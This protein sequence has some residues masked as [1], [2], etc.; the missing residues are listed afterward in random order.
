[1]KDH[2]KYFD[3]NKANWNK[4]VDTH[5]NSDF[6]NIEKFLQTKNSLNSIELSEL[7]EIKNKEL[8]H[9]QCH[10]GQDTISL[11]NLGANTTGVDFS[12]KAIQKAIQLTQ[13]TK[14]HSDFICS[15][16][17]NL[18][19]NLTKKFDIIF[20]SYGTIGWLPDINKWA[21]IVSHFLKPGGKFIIVEFHPFIWMFDDNFEKFQYS[22]F[23][24]DEPITEIPSKTYTDGNEELNVVQYSWNH[25]LSDVTNSLILNDLEITS[26][27]EYNYSPYNC[28]PNMI[29]IETGKYVFKMYGDKL[30]LV[31]SLSATKKI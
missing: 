7:G 12:E 13:K 11:A 20:T 10:F 2:K 30:P 4:R 6:Y 23:H 28:F 27:K 18:K 17:Y 21:E 25:T 31:Y 22:Y 19:E 9:L 16:I 24:D 8:L 29:E 3:A 15:N 26:L 5:F 1:M 14:I